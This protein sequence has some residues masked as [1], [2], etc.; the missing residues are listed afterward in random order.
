MVNVLFFLIA[1]FGYA[2]GSMR[3]YLVY[4]LALAYPISIFVYQW[5]KCI[6]RWLFFKNLTRQDATRLLD[7]PMYVKFMIDR[8]FEFN[9]R[10]LYTHKR[11][12]P[13]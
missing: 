8:V 3:E 7:I 12:F 4:I 2:Y 11:C 9:L 10:K 1:L 13:I 6:G 5:G